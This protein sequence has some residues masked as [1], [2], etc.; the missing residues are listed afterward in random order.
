MMIEK[1]AKLLT[2][3]KPSDKN[4]QTQKLLDSDFPKIDVKL[5]IEF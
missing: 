2:N 1:I 5:D 3:T 4:V